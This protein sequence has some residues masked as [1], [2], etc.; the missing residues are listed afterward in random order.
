MP[1]GEWIGGL[2]RLCV[3]NGE[4]SVLHSTL[5]DILVGRDLHEH[6]HLRHDVLILC[7]ALSICIS[8]LPSR[9]GTA[10]AALLHCHSSADSHYG[11]HL[12]C[13]NATTTFLCFQQE[14][15]PYCCGVRLLY[16]RFDSV[17][18]T[19]S[20]GPSMCTN[21][22]IDT[23]TGRS[24]APLCTHCFRSFFSGMSDV[25]LTSATP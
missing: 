15:L 22:V 20:T 9:C 14:F 11:A 2:W 4:W 10:G 5:R 16:S 12:Q 19:A 25:A 3:L 8:L 21:V 7:V 6:A 17:S 24:Y 23:S 1:C 18:A 13:V